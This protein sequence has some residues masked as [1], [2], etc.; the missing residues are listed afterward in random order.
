MPGDVRVVPTDDDARFS[1]IKQAAEA[2]S[3]RGEAPATCQI[4]IPGDRPCTEAAEV[5]LADPWGDTV[6]GC[7]DHVEEALLNARSAFIATED[8]QGLGPYLQSRRTRR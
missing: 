1:L 4:G 8:G 7:I 5:K 6:W 2:V 3:R